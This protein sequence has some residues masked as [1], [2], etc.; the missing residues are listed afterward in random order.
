MEVPNMD[1]VVVKIHFWSFSVHTLIVTL[2]ITEVIYLLS[3]LEILTII[4]VP[5]PN[6]RSFLNKDLSY[7]IVHS[8]FGGGE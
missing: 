5:V 2:L 4:R 3:K 7:R 1:F 6:V 8:D